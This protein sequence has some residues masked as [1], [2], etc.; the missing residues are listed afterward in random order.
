MLAARVLPSLL[1][2]SMPSVAVSA[3]RTFSSCTAAAAS[4]SFL[5]AKDAI[6][7]LPERPGN[8]VMLQLYALFK[9]ATEGANK[10]PAPGMMDFVGKAKWSAWH[11]L[12]DISKEEAEARYIALCKSLGADVDGTGA[13]AAATATDA[14]AAPEGEYTTLIVERKENGVVVATMNR[15][16]KKNAIS[17]DMYLE[18]QRVMAETA[19]DPKA[20]ALVLT[21]KGDWYSSGNDLSNFTE[22]MPAGGPGEMAKNA[23]ALLKGFVASFIDFPLPLI[24]AVNGPA[25]GIPVTTLG[26]CDFVYASHTA[27]FETP[28]T[29]LGQSPEACSS[30]VFPRIMGRARANEVLL[31]GKKLTAAEACEWGLVNEVFSSTDFK[32]QVAARADAVAAL[33]PQSMRLSKELIN[34][35]QQAELHAVNAAECV[36][37]QERWVSDECMGAIMAFM[38][39]KK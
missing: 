10:S 28:F 20:R 27:T 4:E 2:R 8:D 19:A 5:R 33:P 32:A 38:S 26:L 22:N 36:L 14:P 30:V 3:S 7:D 24:A 16:A 11:D 25:V 34:S 29:R 1:R 18:L 17:M 21:G 6:K 15:P 37:L 12:G 31:A 13:A 9:Q 23:A 39:R 35:T